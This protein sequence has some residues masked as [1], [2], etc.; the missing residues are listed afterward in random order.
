M[1]LLAKLEADYLKAKTEKEILEKEVNRC[2]IQL[3]RA[4]KLIKGLGGEKENWR[5]KS[6]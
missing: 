6:I 4:E 2:K 1:D 3:E 5:K